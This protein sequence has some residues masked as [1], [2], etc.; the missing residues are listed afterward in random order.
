MFHSLIKKPR[1]ARTIVAALSAIA[2]L[3]VLPSKLAA[4]ELGRIAGRVNGPDGNAIAGAVVALLGTNQQTATDRAGQFVLE[5]VPVGRQRIQ[6]RALGRKPAEQVVE[7][8]AGET[9]TLSVAV[10]LAPVELVG[11]TVTGE[12]GG[13]I[14]SAEQKRRSATISDVTSG[15]E[16]GLLPDQNVAE[17]VQRIPGIYMETS[18][19]E[20]R[21]V[22]IRGI[23]PNLNNV[24]LNGQQMATTSSDRSQTLDLLPASMVSNI[25]VVKAVT[26]DMDANTIGGTVNLRTLSAFDRPRPF[27]FGIAEGVFTSR[28]VD[29]GPTKQP[30]ELDITT[31]RRFGPN[32]SFG[33]VL[34]GSASQ[35][36]NA[37]A[38]ADPDG[39]IRVR[40]STTGDSIDVS[41]ELELQVADND[42]TRYSLSSNLDWRPSAGTEM[43]LR[44]LYTRTGEQERNSE[45]EITFTGAYQFPDNGRVGRNTASSIELDISNPVENEDLYSVQLGGT[46]RWRNLTLDLSGVGTRGESHRTAIDATFEN[47]RATD[48]QVPVTLDFS[49]YFYGVE[50][51]DRTFISNAD[52]IPLQG[53]SNNER[54]VVDNTQIGSVDLR[55]DGRLGRYPAF[56]KVGAKVTSRDRDID[57]RSDRFTFPYRISLANYNEPVVGGL[58]GGATPFQQGSVDK[59]VAFANRNLYRDTFP[60]DMINSQIQAIDGDAFVRERISAG[61][62]MG[63]VE[64]GRLSA[65]G[66]VRVERTDSDA[67]FWELQEN[68]RLPAGQRYT[69]PSSR[70][71]RRNSYT[72]VLPAAIFK[73]DLTEDLLVR[74]AYTG[75]IARPQFT[76]L[77]S[78]TRA[79][80]IPDQNVPDAF[81][82]TVSDNNPELK[83]YESQNYDVSVEFYPRTGGSLSL[84]YFSKQIDNPIF[85]FRTTAR[86]T[87]YEGRFFTRLQYTQQRNGEAGSLGGVELSWSQP[88]YFLP[89][90][91]NGLGIN[92]N[93]AFITSELEIVGRDGTLPFLGQPDNVINITPY[94]QRGPFEVRFAYARRSEFLT[95]VDT[96]VGFDRFTA[97]RSTMD[98]NLRWQLQGP[99]WEII[100]TGRNLSNA[101]EVRYQGKPDQYDLHVLTGRTFSIG[102]RTTR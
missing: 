3:A 30:Y 88:L 86:D 35:R 37:V 23:A 60:Q 84:A 89:G 48:A 28:Q 40:N 94:Y 9:S 26:P 96:R 8:R 39:W 102:V 75:T 12:R 20:G 76:Q 80:Y 17:A 59:F 21:T 38:V 46:R 58:Q 51:E 70:T 2:V 81:D 24:T 25:E 43:Y 53:M 49:R 101:P 62:L 10:E 90:A 95:S 54:F 55:A 72:N 18:R 45:F 14:R 77:A 91:L 56:L 47:P 92:A 44:G 93:V 71:E 57:D 73:L 99:R 13:Q 36:D 78:F 52:N 69:F 68:S 98:L 83:P 66:G 50:P 5:R 6:I 79:N 29:Y 100:A 19:G 34:S 15:D 82:G 87:T 32:E 74:A 85:T 27:F 16:I 63:S 65:V 41:N 7:V 1:G 31:G 61:Y 64:I 42:R 67:S 97:A 11:I 33:I 22:S 4:Q